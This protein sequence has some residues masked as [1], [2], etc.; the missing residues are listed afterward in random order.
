MRGLSVPKPG[1][2]DVYEP[3]TRCIIIAG[4]FPRQ[5][6]RGR[7]LKEDSTVLDMFFSQETIWFGLPALGGTALF[8]IRII[9]MFSGFFDFDVDAELDINAD[10]DHTG[11]LD[12]DAAFK[13]LSLQ[14]I[15]AFAMGFGWGGIG[16]M[17]GAGW[18]LTG[19]L[20]A[21]LFVGA[22]FVWLLGWLMKVVYGLQSSGNVN[23]DDTIGHTGEVYVTIPAKGQGTGQVRMTI[24]DRQ[25][26]YKA[27]TEGE[28]IASQ[29]RVRVTRISDDRTLTVVAE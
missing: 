16:A 10:I 22:V 26:I 24:R 6:I 20:F 27:M 8:I 4:R 25:R 23:I 11:V 21:G 1:E 12:P 13:L 14:S 9:F 19:S 18:E 28:E 2:R 5:P 15:A 7:H 3:P 29:T 17:F